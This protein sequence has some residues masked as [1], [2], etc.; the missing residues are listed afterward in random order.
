MKEEA[1]VQIAFAVKRH[2]D[3]E[4]IRRHARVF[5]NVVLQEEYEDDSDED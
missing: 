2:P 3:H 1:V 5:F 4:D